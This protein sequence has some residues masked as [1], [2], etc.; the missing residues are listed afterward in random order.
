MN[1]D[2]LLLEVKKE[3]ERATELFGPFNSKHEGFAV[4]EEEF[5]ELREAVFWPHKIKDANP[6]EEAIQLAAMAVRLVLDTRKE[7]ENPSSS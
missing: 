7:D 5:L 6:Y 1:V 3:L 4:I 2:E